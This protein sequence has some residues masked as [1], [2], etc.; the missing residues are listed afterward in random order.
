MLCHKTQLSAGVCHV[1]VP[2]RRL[3]LSGKQTMY[4]QPNKQ[5][6]TEAVCIYPHPLVTGGDLSME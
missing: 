4:V 1:P 6:N 5:G 3:F 2:S